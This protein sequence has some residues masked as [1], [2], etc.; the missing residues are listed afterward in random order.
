[1]KLS[2]I[3][4]GIRHKIRPFVPFGSS[5]IISGNLDETHVRSIIDFACGDGSLLQAVRRAMKNNRQVYSVG[6]DIFAP[7]LRKARARSTYDDYILCDVEWLPLR[8][9]SSDVVLASNILEHLEKEQGWK[10]LEEAERVARE[11]VLIVVPNGFLLRQAFGGNVYE[12]HKSAWRNVELKRRGYGIRGSGLPNRL[13]TCQRGVKNYLSILVDLL[14]IMAGPF[15]HLLPS[16]AS[17][18]ICTK[19]LQ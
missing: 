19:R 7:Y 1:M 6:L 16:F 10:L 3:L 11:K 8:C 2:E 14:T 18:I 17:Q 13:P 4:L 12:E 5:S 9:K 15:V